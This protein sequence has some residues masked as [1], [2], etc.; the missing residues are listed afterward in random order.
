MPHPLPDGIAA[1]SRFVDR[2]A[3]FGG[4][5]VL[6][7]AGISFGRQVGQCNLNSYCV[8]AWACRGVSSQGQCT[9]QGVFCNSDNCEPGAGFDGCSWIYSFACWGPAMT[10]CCIVQNN[11]LN[12]NC[13]PNCELIFYNQCTCSCQDL[14]LGSVEGG[15][16]VQ[17]FTQ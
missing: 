14:G 6:V 9:P 1:R 2:F 4:T 11:V 12:T 7:C 3:S 16:P 8:N 15:K 5:A 13:G 10:S 17:C